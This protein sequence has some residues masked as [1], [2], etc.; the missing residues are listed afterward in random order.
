MKTSKGVNTFYWKCG[1]DY[2]D[3]CES[4]CKGFH[5]LKSATDSFMQHV[6]ERNYNQ[7]VITLRPIV[8][9]IVGG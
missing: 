6:Y 7:A 4:I 9:V 2:S 5:T 8:L 1:Y 3:F